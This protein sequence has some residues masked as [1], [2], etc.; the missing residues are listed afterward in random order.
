MSNPETTFSAWDLG[1]KGLT[2]TTGLHR[3]GIGE[4]KTTPNQGI[5]VI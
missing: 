5:A 3:I 4:L 2:A 1:T